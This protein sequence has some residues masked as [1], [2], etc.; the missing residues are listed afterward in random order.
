MACKCSQLLVDSRN[1]VVTAST[2]PNFS[3]F[4]ALRWWDP[5]RREPNYPTQPSRI[6]H[7]E[8]NPDGTRVFTSGT[9]ELDTWYDW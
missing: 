4:S 7:V 3:S 6:S 2:D 1:R 5:S 8:I 9:W